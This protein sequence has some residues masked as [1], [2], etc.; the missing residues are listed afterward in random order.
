MREGERQVAPTVDGIR[1]DHVARYKFAAERL[2]GKKVIDAGCG[3]GYGSRILADA[4][5]FVTAF[6]VS[7]EAI[8]YAKA[9]YLN[10]EHDHIAF[11]VRDAETWQPDD[12]MTFDAAVC[13]EIIEHLW[14]PAPLLR[15]L[16]HAAPMLLASVPNEEVFPYQNHAYHYRHYTSGEFQT[17]L[18]ACGWEVVEWHGQTGKESGVEENINGRTLIAVCQRRAGKPE[19][20]EPAAVDL[21]GG[22]ERSIPSV[23]PEH[24]AI[25]ALGPSVGSYLEFTKRL[26]GRDKFCDEVWGINAIGNVFE[27]DRVF[28]MDDVRI[29]EIRAQASPQGN[30]AAMLPWLRRHPGPVYTSRPHPDYPGLVAYP[31]EEVVRD[32]GYAYM[33]STA[34]HA[35]A[36]AVY[37]RVKKITLFGMDFTYE[38]S[39]HA[40]KGRACV[41]FWLGIAAARGIQISIPQKSSLMDG[42]EPPRE[43]LYGYDTVDVKI[44]RDSDGRHAVSFT[45]R[46]GPL[47]SAEEIEKR[48]DHTLHPNPLI[49]D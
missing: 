31:L 40:E 21:G 9:H 25:L 26:G 44:A 43:R 6:D 7:E 29:Q 13:F 4:G 39:H 24:V 3:I 10:R 27:C 17:L 2:A 36:F 20:R 15:A 28:H 42:C 22:R 19:V 46:D 47:P 8:G 1:A 11:L 45:E 34:A 41:E 14:D 35:V 30:I 33:N 5:C 18:E 12:G 23:A 37:L 16:R 32:T 49:K 48:Y 38:H